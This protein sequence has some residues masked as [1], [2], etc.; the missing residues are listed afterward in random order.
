MPTRPDLN[1]SFYDHLDPKAT[2]G[3]YTITVEHRLTKDGVEVD[4]NAKLPKASDSYE[5]RAAQ[6]FLD[7]SSVHATYPPTGAVGRY[8]H[9]LPHL[10]LSRAILPWERQLLGRMAA[11]EPWLA[12]LVFAEGELDDDPDAQ[13]EFTTRPISELREPGSGIN[14]PELSGTIDGSNPCRTID[15]PVSVF[16]AVVARQE[17]LFHLVHMRDVHTAPQRRDNG[18]ILT[19]GE[20]AVLAANRFPRTPGNYAVHLVS[21]E[22]WLGRLDPGT[23]P[24][25]EKVRLCSLWSWHFTNDPEGSLDPAG[26][27]R[28]L[29]APGYKEPEN[30]ALRLAPTGEPSSSPETEY[31]RTR[32]HRGYTAVAYRTLAGEDTY[33]W[34][35]GPLTPLTA[36]ELPVEAVAGPHTTADHALIYDREYGLFDVSYAAAWTLGRAIALADPDYSSEVVQARRELANRAATL[37]ALSTDPA[38]AA[39]DPAEPA[40][41]AALRELAAPGFGRRLLQALEG[42]TVQGPLPA[43]AVRMARMETGALLAEPRAQQS[44]LTVAQDTTPTMPDWLERLALLNGVPFAHLVPDPRMLPPESLRAFRIDPAWIHALVAGAA[45]VGAH[46]SLDHSLNPVL[47]ERLSRV[48]TATPVAGLLMNSELVRAWPVFDI[49]ATTADGELVKELRRDHLAPDVLLV[50]WDAVPDQIAIREPGQGIHFGINSEERISLRHLTGNRV[51]Y[52]TDTE[53]PDPGVPGSGTVFDYLRPGQG[54]ALPDVLDLGGSGGLLRALS[55]ACRPSGDLTPGQFALEL[56]N[57]P[58]EQLLLPSTVRRDCVADTFAQYGSGASDFGTTNP[59]M[60]KNEGPTSTT[61]RIAYLRFDTTQL[62]P[63]EQIGKALLRVYVAALDAGDFD[64]TAYATDNDWGESTLAWANKPALSAS[65]IASAHVGAVDAWAWLEFDITA[66]LRQ[67]SGDELSVAL[68]RDAQGGNKLAR[69]TSRE[70]ATNQPH[71][72]ITITQPTLNSGEDRC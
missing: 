16:H 25:N 54:A 3:V 14:G 4:A 59:L 68:S 10:T 13:G 42:P 39:V 57:A 64:L 24:A 15:L 49:L 22:G 52:P 21:L 1:V 9:V 36:P 66:H 58:L 56:V 32:L 69:I 48:D 45:D 5:I 12:L 61:T 51:G 23:L 70:A 26:L 43:P 46:T 34:Y 18:E 65:P 55:A 41:T 53:F 33:A 29:V 30:L 60:V 35:R 17:E 19:K 27:L 72:S 40:G 20:Y 7:P 11:K 38:R 2:A 63:S 31:A 50:L 47:A 8:T 71:L 62:P 37:L 67:H 6:F 44:L 28:N